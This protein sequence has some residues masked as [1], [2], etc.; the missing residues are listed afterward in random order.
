[1]KRNKSVEIMQNF[2]PEIGHIVEMVQFWTGSEYSEVSIIR[3]G[4]SWLLEFEI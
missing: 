3:P 2:H 4:R 1:M